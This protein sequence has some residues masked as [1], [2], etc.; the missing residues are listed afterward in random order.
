MGNW[1]SWT[2]R[3]DAED[4]GVRTLTKMCHS[5]IFSIRTAGYCHGRSVFAFILE[6]VIIRYDKVARD[7][8][9]VHMIDTRAKVSLDRM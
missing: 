1:Q 3:R 9:I 5:G 8:G 4:A 2:M 7:R 6:V